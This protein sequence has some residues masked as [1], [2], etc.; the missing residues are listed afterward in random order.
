MRDIYAKVG[1]P[2]SPQSPDIGQNSDVDVSD[3]W[4]SGQSFIKQNCHNSRT[5]GDIDTKLGP[6]TKLEKRNKATSNEFVDDAML[7][8]C[9]VIALF[10]NLWLIWRNPKPDSRHSL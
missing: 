10:S 9:I 8:N 1:I 6:V 5:S 3:F 2:N 7:G 4:I